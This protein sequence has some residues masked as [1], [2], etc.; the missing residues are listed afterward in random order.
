MSLL[1]TDHEYESQYRQYRSYQSLDNIGY[2]EFHFD[3]CNLKLSRK[4]VKRLQ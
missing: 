4:D 1:L 2:P 3:H